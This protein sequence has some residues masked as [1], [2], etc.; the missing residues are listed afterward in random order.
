[1]A[2]AMECMMS[3]KHLT[4]SIELGSGDRC[5]KQRWNFLMCSVKANLEAAVDAENRDGIS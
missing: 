1:M 4:T 5:G 3:Q 2:L